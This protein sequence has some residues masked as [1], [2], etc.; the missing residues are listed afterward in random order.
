MSEQINNLKSIIKRATIDDM[1]IPNK[2]A[3]LNKWTEGLSNVSRSFTSSIDDDV[4]E[5]IMLLKD[6]DDSWKILLLLGI[7]IFTD[8]RSTDYS[9]IMKQ[10]ADKQK[11]YLIIADS[12]Y[13]YGTNYQFCHGYLG[14]DLLLT[15]EKI[16]QSLGRIGRSNIQQEYTARFRDISQIN[17]LFQHLSF[18]EKPEVINMNILFNSKNI[19]WNK[20]TLEYEE[21]EELIEEQDEIEEP[22]ELEEIDEEELKM[23]E[24]IIKK[25]RDVNDID[26]EEG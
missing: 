4:V 8:H 5:S 21:I 1:F 6:V 20:D 23:T 14:K 22:E 9:E 24:P 2:L 12:D 13:I 7:G 17:M 26:D 10:L 25:K 19:R 3:H 18:Y 16:I 11:L 15:Q